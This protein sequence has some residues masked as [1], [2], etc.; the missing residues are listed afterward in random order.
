M[1]EKK[2]RD[3]KKK[4]GLDK[5]DCKLIEILQK[6]GRLSN[7][8]I[9]KEMKISEATVRTRLKRLLDE[10]ELVTLP[11]LRA[12]NA[13]LKT[14]IAKIK[15]RRCETCETWAREE[16]SINNAHICKRREAWFGPGNS[17]PWWQSVE[18]K[19]E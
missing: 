12:E 14:E 8:K 9:A 18:T 7:I 5:T 17:C 3:K 6:D 13:D 16:C 4:K 15:R 19:G 2:R 11:A 1:D 10:D